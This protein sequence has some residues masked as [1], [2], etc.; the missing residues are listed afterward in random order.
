MVMI[1]LVLQVKSL[2]LMEDPIVSN[3][4]RPIYKEETEHWGRMNLNEYNFNFGVYF[5]KTV[6]GFD[7]ATRIPEEVGKVISY[8]IVGEEV[9]EGSTRDA[10]SCSD[11]R[12]FTKVN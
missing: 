1:Y 10:V 8:E 6:D 11:P 7:V 4:S 3:Q 9:V 12:L 2:V 5:T